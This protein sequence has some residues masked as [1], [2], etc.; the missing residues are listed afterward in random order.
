MHLQVKAKVPTS[1]M[2][3]HHDDGDDIAVSATYQPG[4]LVA[5]L[6]DPRGDKL[7]SSVCERIRTS[8]SGVSSRSGSMGAPTTRMT[9]PATHAAA[10]HS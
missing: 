7:Q 4:A 8:S 5:M 3:V 9:T 2:S 10:R 6:R 1:G